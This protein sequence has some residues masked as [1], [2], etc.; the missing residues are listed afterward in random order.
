MI[1]GIILFLSYYFFAVL[2]F[3]IVGGTVAP[4]LIF[5][6]TIL[7]L[8]SLM[9]SQIKPETYAF[10]HFTVAVIAGFL[11]A[12][13]IVFYFCNLHSPEITKEVVS[14]VFS[15]KLFNQHAVSYRISISELRG[16]FMMFL[17]YSCFHSGLLLAIP[18]GLLIADKK[19]RWGAILLTC[20]GIGMTLLMSAR[21]FAHHYVIYP[22]FYYSSALAVCL[23]YRNQN[24][25][26]LRHLSGNKSIIAGVVIAGLVI[27]FG[28]MQYEYAKKYYPEYNIGYRNQLKFVSSGFG[29]PEFEKK[30]LDRYGCTNHVMWRVI[31][32]D[33]LNGSERGIK[34]R[35]ITNV[36][37]SLRC[38]GTME[39]PLQNK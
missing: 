39:D 27:F 10:L 22:D 9:I 4:T 14:N 1:A 28:A 7:Y 17:D 20:C 25:L 8:F 32:D 21:Y 24:S 16:H 15:M 38:V 5:A 13:P 3:N 37:D 29:S 34:I 2:G 19:G 30:M 12:T 31:R 6:L 26:I 18:F 23:T 35:N 36:I 33:K 11:L